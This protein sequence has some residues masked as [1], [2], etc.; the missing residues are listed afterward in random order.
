VRRVIA[1]P[2]NSEIIGDRTW[3]IAVVDVTGLLFTLGLIAGRL[4]FARL[5]NY[6]RP[7]EYITHLRDWMLAR[8][9]SS[10]RRLAATSTRRRSNVHFMSFGIKEGRQR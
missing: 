6:L 1:P 4:A 3:A 2:E 8:S 10:R 9:V 7:D 5:Q